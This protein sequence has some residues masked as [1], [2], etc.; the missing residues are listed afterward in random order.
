[1]TDRSR[2]TANIA[3][4]PAVP[5]AMAATAERF[6]GLFI[7][8]TGGAHTSVAKPPEIVSPRPFPVATTG[9]PAAYSPQEERRLPETSIPGT[10][11]N[12]LAIPGWASH[13]SASL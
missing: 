10:S 9:V 5:M 7:I 3:V 4:R 12:F 13:A 2:S 6:W 11:G 8:A 1:M